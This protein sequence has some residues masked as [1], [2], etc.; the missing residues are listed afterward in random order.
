L[1]TPERTTQ[2]PR[3]EQVEV[4]GS[5]LGSASF[6]VEEIREDML[7]TRAGAISN[8][9]SSVTKKPGLT[10]YFGVLIILEWVVGK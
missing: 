10:R 5:R 4:I 2:G 3:S 7:A 1:S 6:V 9:L 8:R